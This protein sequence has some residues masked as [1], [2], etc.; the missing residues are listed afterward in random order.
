M[1]EVNPS[2]TGHR[3]VLPLLGCTL[4]AH[5]ETVMEASLLQVRLRAFINNS[6]IQCFA[7][8]VH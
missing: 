5:V 1:K 3:R 8:P 7:L 2:S 4:D 6:V